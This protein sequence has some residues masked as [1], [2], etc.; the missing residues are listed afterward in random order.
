M[1]ILLK[2]LYVKNN[3]TKW[4][5]EME[6]LLHMAGDISRVTARDKPCYNVN[7]VIKA[8]RYTAKK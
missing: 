2:D 3:K 7:E 4:T 5:E 1:I 6:N 8:L